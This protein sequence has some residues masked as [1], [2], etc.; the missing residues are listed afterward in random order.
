MERPVFKSEK[1]ESNHS[2]LG[3]TLI[4]NF[5]SSDDV[6]FLLNLYKQFHIHKVDGYMWNSLYH[7]SDKESVYISNKIHQILDKKISNLFDNAEWSISTIMSKCPGYPLAFDTPHR[8]YSVFKEDLFEYRQVWIPLIDITPTNGAMYVVP[9]SHKLAHKELPMMQK[10]FYRNYV[11]ELVPFATS[12]MLMKAGDLLVYNDR[13]IHGG[14]PNGTNEER[15]VIHFGV[16][17]KGA[18]PQLVR[19]EGT[20]VAFY[21]VPE[22][23]YFKTKDFSVLPSNT[24]LNTVINDVKLEFNVE[25]LLSK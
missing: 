11:D 22:D 8:D 7:V 4:K 12:P 14:Y 6:E 5:I 1:I 9:K 21:D 17:P 3:Y 2:K 16:Y 25:P 15:P 20:K 24:K 23:F 13:T 10:C 19:S 18:K